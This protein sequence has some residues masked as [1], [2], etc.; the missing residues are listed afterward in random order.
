M[1][2]RFVLG[3]AGTGKTRYCL[4]ELTRAL[5]D[6]KS[7]R[8]LL[9]IVPEQASFQ[10]ERAVALAAPR[11]AFVRA[12]VLSFSRLAAHVL[13]ELG[14]A[15]GC[16]RA[17]ARRLVLQRLILARGATGAAL[18][19]AAR[20]PGFVRVLDRLIEELQREDV[21]LAAFETA[22]QQLDD[23]ARR[24][25]LR[26]LAGV[27]RDYL[28]WLG[29]Q[30]RDA[31][32]RLALVREHL[33]RTPWLDGC[34]IWLDGFAGFTGQELA[35]LVTLARRAARLTV[36]LLLDPASP[37]VQPPFQTPDPLDLFH[38][39]E[40]TYQQLRELFARHGVAID[41]VIDLPAAPPHR[42]AA[43]RE[44]VQ[45]EREFD[46]GAGGAAEAP[47]AAVRIVG[48][49]TP[50][51]ELRQAARF[52]RRQIAESGGRLRLRDFA[53]IARD[54]EPWADLVDEV[55]REYEIP[56]FVDRRRPI[57]AHPLPRLLLE[58]LHA[59]TSDLAGRAALG[60]L[61][62]GLSGATRAQREWLENQVVEHEVHGR[63]AWSAA[64]WDFSADERWSQRG[65]RVAG[66]APPEGTDS[67]R[68]QIVAALKP[69]TALLNRRDA[70]AADWARAVYQA[71][72]TLAVAGQ[73]ADWIRAAQQRDDWEGAELHRLVWES[74]TQLF[75]DLHEVMGATVLS[76]DEL[77]GLLASTLG[78]LSVG[79]APPTLDQVLIGAIERSRHPELQH[80]WI[81]GF[82]EGLFPAR[83]ADDVLLSREERQALV[84]GGLAQ[85]RPRTEEAFNERLLAYI[86]CT[87]ACAGLTISYA[88]V[89]ETGEE[90]HPS[91]LLAE[92]DRALPG[93]QTL[94][95]AD[96]EPP[97]ALLEFAR[98]RLAAAARP[99]ADPLARRHAHLAE[100]LSAGPHAERIARL[101]RGLRYSNRPAPLGNFR[102]PDRPGVVWRGSPSEIE[103]YL[104]C[105]YQHFAR[106]GLWLRE[107]RGPR[108]LDWTLGDATHLLLADWVRRGC[109]PNPRPA[110]TAAWAELFDAAA[111]EFRK[112]LPADLGQRRP[113]LHLLL[114][115]AVEFA[116]EV[117]T[118]QAA[119]WARGK[120]RPLVAEFSFG[121]EYAADVPPLELAAAG[122]A[123]QV[124]GSIDRVDGCEEAGV[125][126]FIVVDYKSWAR[127]VR[128]PFLTQDRLQVFTYLAAFEHAAALLAGRPVPADADLAALHAQLA[129]RTRFDAAGVQLA[130]LRPNPKIAGSNYFEAADAGTKLMYLYRP[131]GLIC[132]PLARTLDEHLGRTV[133]PV[134]QLRTTENGF[135]AHSR[136]VSS[137]ELQAR[138]QLA[139]ETIGH[140]AKGVAAGAIDIAPLVE[141]RR[142]ACAT[143]A[144]RP[145]C[146][147]DRLTNGVRAAERDLPQL[148]VPQVQP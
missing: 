128:A 57:R 118:A 139:R 112:H 76:A 99:A 109:P 93:I 6:S 60:L 19:T 117:A 10:M 80:V 144:Y 101:L 62:T 65:R 141:S 47:P 73:L 18:D 98:E 5:A 116:R 9:L 86:A 92:I 111:A 146:R 8:R 102:A 143:C 91:P 122:G 148:S 87:R 49:R 85:L 27:Y 105:P 90:L 136:V 2:V 50:R 14:G 40:R 134:L 24:E 55:F 70:T 12:Q 104:Q 45:L 4:D 23:P 69:L 26:A 25:K 135:D 114:G 44:L 115:R 82:N 100:R 66:P 79:L 137:A 42:F 56:C 96:D 126:H 106:H 64:A 142:L 30:R 72:Q 84:A 63:A 16:L 3:R 29:P 119:R 107:F 130:P 38:A 58:L 121:G 123:V 138:V 110:S 20:T 1:P 43:A 120:F 77:H 94:V 54:L 108:P 21:A 32:A 147:F 81:V 133:S 71:L 34:A 17:E 127:S 124:T 28:E 89:S 78:E 61:R 140:A 11:Q 22:A 13:A 131:D 132:E 83:P 7:A 103:K 51:D 95:P 41:E 129:G 59:A 37:A 68:L 75:D 125:L 36:T 39:T 67:V 48:C 35:T 88:A 53:V 46:R 145:V 113:Q 52:I 15:A 97:V 74:V 31:A 33:E